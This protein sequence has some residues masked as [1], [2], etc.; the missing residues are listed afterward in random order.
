[1]YK[2]RMEHKHTVC[3]FGDT[4]KGCIEFRLIIYL[5]QGNFYPQEGYCF[6]QVF[7]ALLSC[8]GIIFYRHKKM[9][10]F[11]RDTQHPFDCFGDTAADLN[12]SEIAIW[13]CQAFYK[14]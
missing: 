6:L 3:I 4:C 2:Y 9:V 14:S 10:D 8:L 7:Q 1:M 11:R 12:A 5:C 13:L